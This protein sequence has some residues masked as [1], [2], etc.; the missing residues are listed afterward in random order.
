M[1]NASCCQRLTAVLHASVN[2]K[3]AA[4]RTISINRIATINFKFHVV[5]KV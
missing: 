4:I 3:L 2:Y 1:T 5:I